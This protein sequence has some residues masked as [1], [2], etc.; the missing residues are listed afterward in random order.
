MAACSGPEPPARPLPPT[1]ASPTATP[2][3]KRPEDAANAFFNAW[4]QGQYSAMY[5]LLSADAQSA[6]PRDVFVRRYTNIHS[7]IAEL[8][9]TVQPSGAATDPGQAPFKVTRTLAVVAD[10]SEPTTPPAP[11]DPRRVGKEACQPG[12]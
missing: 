7:G 8:N 1:A 4:Q 6:T 11:Q 5:D 10:I 12:Q 2:V 3:P 9:L